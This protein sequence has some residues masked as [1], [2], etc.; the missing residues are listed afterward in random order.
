[1][2]LRES[3][4]T[5]YILQ[6]KTGATKNVHHERS[7]YSQ[8]AHREPSSLSTSLTQSKDLWVRSF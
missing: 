2:I 7:G 5:V 1:M 4:E 6:I 8:V 3:K